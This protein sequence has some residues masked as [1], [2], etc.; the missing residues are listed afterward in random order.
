[1]AISRTTLRYLKKATALA[2]PKRQ[3]QE[4]C[5]NNTQKNRCLSVIWFRCHYKQRECMCIF[6]VLVYLT[7]C[8]S[9]SLSISVFFSLDFMHGAARQMQVVHSRRDSD[10]GVYWC[11][12]EN[13]W[14]IARSRNAT[15]QV[16]GKF[17]LTLHSHCMPFVF[18]PGHFFPVSLRM[19]A[20]FY[21]HTHI[22]IVNSR[23]F[24]SFK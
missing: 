8:F 5:N 10:A 6:W 1:M 3:L 21:T 12:C 20:G 14:G 2:Q 18:I 23:F 24:F 7:R 11:I 13:D 4:E 9:E 19:S 17:W 15:L 16:A 22:Y